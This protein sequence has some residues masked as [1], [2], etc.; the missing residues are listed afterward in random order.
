[1]SAVVVAVDGGRA[2][3]F[4]GRVRVLARCAVD[5]VAA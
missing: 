3:V 2:V 5:V 4:G 1:M